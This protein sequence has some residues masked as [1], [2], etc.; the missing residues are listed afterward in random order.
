MDYVY[1][2]ERADRGSDAVLRVKTLERPVKGMR[3][4]ISG[5]VTPIAKLELMAKGI[6]VK[7]NM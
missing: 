5:R 2:T 3:L 6:V 7:E 1:W 4:F